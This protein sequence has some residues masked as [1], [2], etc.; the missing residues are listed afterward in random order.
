MSD[1]HV[2]KDWWGLAD[3]NPTDLKTFLETATES[4]FHQ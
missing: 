3:T 4:I 1:I 2:I